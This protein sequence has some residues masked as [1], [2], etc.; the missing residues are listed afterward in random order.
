MF[1]GF[2]LLFAAFFAAFFVIERYGL[3]LS[4]FEGHVEEKR[5]E[6]FK[7]LSLAAD[8]KKERLLRWLEERRDD[9][10]VIT[11]SAIVKSHLED[12]DNVIRREKEA[13]KSG[14]DLWNAVRETEAYRDLFQHLELVR[15]TY[16]VY[17]NIQIA[18]ARTGIVITGTHAADLGGEVFDRERFDRAAEAG[19]PLIDVW[20]EERDREMQLHILKTFR[21]VGGERPSGHNALAAVLIMHIGTD[22]F[23]VPFLHTGGGLGATGEA[24]LVNR[25]VRIITPLKHRLADGSEAVPMEYRIEALPATRGARG[26]EGIIE[27]DDY[28][29]E[30]VLAAY[31][32]IPVSDEVGWGMVV[33]RDTAEILRHYHRT[34]M[35][36]TLIAVIGIL[37]T[38]GL[39][40]LISRNLTRPVATLSSTAR[41]VRKGDLTA[42]APVTGTDEIRELAEA[43]NSMVERVQNWNREMDEKVRLR[44]AELDR[45]NEE[46]QEEIKAR[47]AVQESHDQLNEALRAKNEE[48]EQVINVT[49]HDLRSPLVNIHGFSRELEHLAGEAATLSESPEIPP[50]LAE[51]LRP[52]LSE[53]VPEALS[54][55][56]RGASRMD[57]LIKGLLRLSRLGRAALEIKP[58]DMNLLLS[59]VTGVFSYQLQ[60]SGAS[61][62]IGPLPPCLGDEVQV[63][64]VFSNLLDNALKYLD[65]SRPGVIRVSGREEDGRAIY[66]VED[67]GIGIDPDY[68]DRIFEIFHRLDPRAGTGDGLGLTTVRKILD[69]QNGAISVQS[70]PGA[71][72]LFTVSLP[73]PGRR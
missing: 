19:G 25:D 62:E 73:S 42:R 8:L 22:D 20:A 2:G 6:A 60:K 1:I 72:C 50:H 71:G 58:L 35:T 47:R 64:Q 67:N 30:P 40:H 69:R 23:I 48:L 45:K 15:T 9:A 36:T 18:D 17:R 28:R 55:I 61:I 49:S 65:P 13:G 21:G 12:L 27:T 16:K 46:L 7:S 41:K 57:R 10:V 52:I 37:L 33:K 53:Q 4:G 56:L 5:T 66:C 63:N 59:E 68:F 24:L 32:Y 34:A 3:P 43:F 11:Q 29:G 26:E 54:F 14:E 31:R 39:T 70:P 44:T 38:L 51:K